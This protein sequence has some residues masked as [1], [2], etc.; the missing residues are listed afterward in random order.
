[1][2][3]QVRAWEPAAR[4][5]T[6]LLASPH[7]LRKS[8]AQARA[9]NRAKDE[10]LVTLSHELRTPLN[11]SSGGSPC[12]ARIGAEG[13][14]R[15]GPGE[16]ERNALHQSEL[17][18]DLLDISEDCDGQSAARSPSG[19]RHADS[20][21]RCGIAETERRMNASASGAVHHS[22][23]IARA[24]SQRLQQIV[25]N[26]V[27]NAI[28]FTPPGGRIDV[29][30]SQDD[31]QILLAVR[32]T[33]VGITAKFLPHVFERFRQ[34]DSSTTRPHSGLGLGL[35]IVR[36]LVEL[37]GG[38]IEAFSE[39]RDCGAYSKSTSALH[40]R[41]ALRRLPRWS[42]ATAAFRCSRGHT[43]PRRRQRSRHVRAGVGGV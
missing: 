39:G 7:A 30:L 41:P 12:C 32:D 31:Q 11:T 38:S 17:I 42:P 28:K 6:Q 14:P 18:E 10:F 34:A 35:A 23:L 2:R 22:S 21:R 19:C 25:W 9:A 4:H 29:E 26:L 43:S 8:E 16:I 15:P 20:D 33:G 40:Q 37:H 13:T 3:A 36:D 1:M 5:E 27:S 24:D